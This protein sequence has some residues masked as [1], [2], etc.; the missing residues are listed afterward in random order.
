MSREKVLEIL[1]AQAEK[2][3]PNRRVCKLTTPKQMK[4]IVEQIDFEPTKEFLSKEKLQLKADEIPQKICFEVFLYF[5]LLSEYQDIFLEDDDIWDMEDEKTVELVKKF[6]EL[7][8]V[9]KERQV[10]EIALESVVNYAM[11]DTK[12]DF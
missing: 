4:Q 11:D 8:E 12:E 5:I 9:K 3:V 10:S 2:K 7:V 6:K 1:F